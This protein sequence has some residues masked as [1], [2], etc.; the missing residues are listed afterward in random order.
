MSKFI[1]IINNLFKN[2]CE[3]V[4]WRK[5]VFFG[6]LFSGEAMMRHRK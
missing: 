5:S 3:I 1:S 4:A 2:L 6:I